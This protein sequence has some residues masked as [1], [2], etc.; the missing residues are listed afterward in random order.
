MRD[1]TSRNNDAKLRELIHQAPIGI[2]LMDDA[3]QELILNDQWCAITGLSR[4]DAKN[5]GW[6]RTVHPDDRERV[7]GEIQQCL[8]DRTGYS[9]EFRI[10]RPDGRIN[11]VISKAAPLSDTPGEPEGFIVVMTDVVSQGEVEHQLVRTTQQLR[12]TIRFKFSELATLTRTLRTPLNSILGLSA[13][14][15]DEL[16]QAKHGM[17]VRM[18]YE[19]SLRLTRTIDR[20]LELS[21]PGASENGPA[22]VA[23][24][25]APVVQTAA[26]RIAELARTKG[27]DVK[28]ILHHDRL[29][30]FVDAAMLQEAMSHV[31][32]NAL[33][34]TT[35]GTV[36]VELEERESDGRLYAQIAVR[37]TGIGIPAPFHTSVFEPFFQVSNGPREHYEGTGLGLTVAKR[38]VEDMNGTIAL[39]S[40]PD[41][42]T[43]VSFR[44][45]AVHIR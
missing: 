3:G 4:N 40:A 21:R 23:I 34:F 30:A 10:Q 13:L 43:R 18:I 31:L 32:D 29:A 33:K 36:E 44:F 35:H 1:G 41:Q 17:Y 8:K 42:G 9:I 14:L 27:V 11:W 26:S 19:S 2:F 37:D 24:D 16:E 28:V 39:Q 22:L 5:M 38:I 45:P 20:I 25:L 15:E 6:L 12:D 7:E